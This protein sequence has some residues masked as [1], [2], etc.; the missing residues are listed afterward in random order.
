MKNRVR[1]RLW[2]EARRCEAGEWRWFTFEQDG[3]RRLG[4]V[5]P[6][7]REWIFRLDAGGCWLEQRTTT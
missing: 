4:L 1:I 7:G 3:R 2:T 6:G 5:S